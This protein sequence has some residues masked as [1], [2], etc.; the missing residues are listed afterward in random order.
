PHTTSSPTFHANARARVPGSV[1]PINI[2]G[3]ATR[4]SPLPAPATAAAAYT[5]SGAAATAPSASPTAST[6]AA[7]VTVARGPARSV[8]VPAGSSVTRP[9][10]ARADAA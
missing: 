8:R 5:A 1:S 10:P 4:Q 7:V 6:T 9:P 3:M 2:G